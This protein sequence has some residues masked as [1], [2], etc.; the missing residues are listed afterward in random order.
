[1]ASTASPRKLAPGPRGAPLVGSAITFG[2]DPRLALMA[3]AREF[4]PTVRIPLGP[5]VA[6]MVSHPDDVKY[7]LQTRNDRFH[8]APRTRFLTD[9]LGPSMLTMEDEPWM[10]RRR[11][12]QPA[13][14]RERLAEIA[15]VMSAGAHRMVDRWQPYARSGGPFDVAG[16]MMQVTLGIAGETL[17][18]V[19]LGTSAAEVGRALSVVLE[20]VFARLNSIVPLPLW[21]PTRANARYHAA[22]RSLDERFYGVIRDFRS[23]RTEPR[24]LMAML[25][26]ARDEDTGEG[27]TD[28]ELRN[29]VM[30]LVFA[31]HETTACALTWTFWLLAQN[32]AATRRLR[33]ELAAVLGGRAPTAADLPRLAYTAN[34]VKEAMRLLPPAWVIGRMPLEDIEIGGYHVP[35]R[36]MVLVSPC[37][38]HRDPAFWDDP[39]TFDPDRFTP[40]RSAG[41]HRMAYYPFSGGGRVCIGSAFSMM[42]ATLV[43][44]A[45]LQRYRLSLDPTRPVEIDA[46]LTLRPKHGLWMTAHAD[47]VAADAGDG[48]RAAA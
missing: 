39:D 31:G 2:K 24:G 6:H 23:G 47:P 15:E 33:A 34:A 17:F 10:R 9:F 41:R 13:F 1:M 21:L 7:V 18:G 45:V 11:L 20:H 8:K 19:D 4:G 29:E 46:A 38:T 42:E 28:E 43:V 22:V 48:E 25:L 5:L 3:W 44:A 32:P 12:A 14:H 26:A 36:T 37:V 30:T 27:L 16:E 40:E 35:A